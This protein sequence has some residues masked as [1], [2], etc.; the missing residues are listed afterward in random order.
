MIFVSMSGN[1]EE[2]VDYIVGVIC[3]IENEIEVID[4]MDLLEVFIL[5]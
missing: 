2:M 4:I 3:E 1:I 5:E